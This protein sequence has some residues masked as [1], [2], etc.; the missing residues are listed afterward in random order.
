MDAQ[1]GRETAP[2][3]DVEPV[4]GTP[5]DQPI[6]DVTNDQDSELE[7]WLVARDAE[8]DEMA[9]AIADRYRDEVAQ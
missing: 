2:P 4:D 6:P 7:A 5:H 8:L 3:T 1:Y 9:W